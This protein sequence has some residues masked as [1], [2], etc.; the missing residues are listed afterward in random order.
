M[1]EIKEKKKGKW[2]SFKNHY[3]TRSIDYFA[4]NICKYI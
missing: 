2:Q 4:C 3:K 1:S